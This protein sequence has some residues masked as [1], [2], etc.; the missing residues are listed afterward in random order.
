M[1]DVSSQSHG[2]GQLEP[3]VR[4][5]NL[6]LNL[7]QSNLLE[8]QFVAWS[9]CLQISSQ[10]VN[11]IPLLQGRS[12]DPT[13]IVVSSHPVAHE[14][15]LVLEFLMQGRESL[16][17]YCCSGDFGFGSLSKIRF[18]PKVRKERCCLGGL[19]S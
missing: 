12:L 19:A 15:Q 18:V 5:C 6:L 13:L 14:V 11:F 4:S 9:S 17:S 1:K 8:I 2:F 16:C 3:E 10:Q 7:K